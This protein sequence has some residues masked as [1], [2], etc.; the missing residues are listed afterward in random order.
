M[1]KLLQSG[2]QTTMLFSVLCGCTRYKPVEK[3]NVLFIA[4]DD[5]NDWVGFLGGHPQTMTPNMD[6]LA[7]QSVI[8]TRAYCAA[9]V[10][11]PSRAALMTGIRPASSGIY[12]N[13]NYMR[14]S[15]VLENIQTIPQYFSENGYFTTS[16]GKIFH[17][18]NG[19]WAD[20]ISWDKFVPVD[21]NGMNNHPHRTSD[22]LACGMPIHENRQKNFDWGGLDIDKKQTSDWK[23]A[24][25]AASFLNEKHDKPF[26][27]ACGIF[28]PHLPWYVP[29]EY[30]NRF[31]V[32]SIILP[33]INENDLD[34]VPY[35]GKY[36]MSWGLDPEGDFQRIKKYGLQKEVVRA[37]LACI[38]YADDCIGQVLDA[39][40]NSKF[41]DNTIVV[42][43]GDH[44][45]NLGQ[46]LHYRK[47]VLWEEATRMPLLIKVPGV[48]KGIRCERTVNLLDL[49]P[50]LLDLCG[51][52]KNEMNQGNTIAKLVYYPNSE[53]YIPSVTTMGFQ[54]HAVRTERW[55]Y[56]RYEDGS[57]ELYDH[58]NDSLEWT[59]LAND[60]QYS[61]LKIELAKYLLFDNVPE[62]GADATVENNFMNSIPE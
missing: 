32:D 34:D 3:Y 31:N 29:Q 53:W 18:P 52:P 54:R 46:K 37:Y 5:L 21:G 60:P 55:R 44:G 49:Y 61:E 41:K 42:L 36:K 9:S 19:K 51:L 24:E 59:N 27:L 22:V 58:K 28:R 4:V 17:S 20:T 43:W 23:T 12:G 13:G 47:F 50:T 56:I 39:L 57:E 8:F 14:D 30:F 7:S 62:I 38:N 26:F 33:M 11:N 25:W 40:E 2:L 6:R 35:I 48:T 45:W 10:C 15:K 1:N 16:R